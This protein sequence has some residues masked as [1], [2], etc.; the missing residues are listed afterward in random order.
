MLDQ[1]SCH[2]QVV[3]ACDECSGIDEGVYDAPAI[4]SRSVGNISKNGARGPARF[5]F[6]GNNI[7]IRK[8]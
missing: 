3:H 8:H 4:S 5:R 1:V 2:S 7:R 6:A